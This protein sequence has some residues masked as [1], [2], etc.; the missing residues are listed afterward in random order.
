[1]EDG[2]EVMKFGKSQSEEFEIASAWEEL[3]ARIDT[4][5]GQ[6]RAGWGD[7]EEQKTDMRERM[8]MH[9]ERFNSRWGVA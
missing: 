7:G 3:N 2:R 1:M 8:R 9:Q 4:P 5:T 6:S